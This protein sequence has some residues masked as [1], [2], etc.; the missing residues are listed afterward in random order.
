[1][2]VNFQINMVVEGVEPCVTFYKAL[3]FEETYRTPSEGAAQHADALARTHAR[4]HACMR[5]CMRA[6]AARP[7]ACMARDCIGRRRRCG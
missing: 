6:Y 7:I 1:M 5:A 3:G 4:T 2:F